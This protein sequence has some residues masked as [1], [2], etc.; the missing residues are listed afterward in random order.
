M[1]NLSSHQVTGSGR[2]D[3][4]PESKSVISSSVQSRF[5]SYRKDVEQ[6]ETASSRN[7]GKN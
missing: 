6:G 7:Q 4:Q 1:D 3:S 5:E 2:S